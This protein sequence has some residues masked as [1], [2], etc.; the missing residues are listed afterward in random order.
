V[1]SKAASISPDKK[2]SIK[3]KEKV[4]KVVTEKKPTAKAVSK[5]K[6]EKVVATP[7]P[8]EKAKPKPEIKK[9]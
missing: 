5:S 1:D 8:K 6:K 3:Q 4:E 2:R 7:A 9:A